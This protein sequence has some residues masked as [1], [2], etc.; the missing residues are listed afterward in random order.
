MD[1]KENDIPIFSAQKEEY[2]SEFGIY[3]SVQEMDAEH[4]M[5]KKRK[6]KRKN[7]NEKCVNNEK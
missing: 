2:G 3:R 6:N 4:K 1:K 7:E 5:M